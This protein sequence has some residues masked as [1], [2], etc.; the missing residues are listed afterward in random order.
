MAFLLPRPDCPE[1]EKAKDAYKISYL[2]FAELLLKNSS[3]TRARWRRLYN[4]R[5]G[6]KDPL[7]IQWLTHTYGQ[8][9]KAPFISYY[10][11][12]TALDVVH[13]N[14]LE[15]PLVA[16]VTTVN[17]SANAERIRQRDFMKGAML[18]RDEI[19]VVKNVAGVDIMNG[20]EI[21]KDESEFEKLNF[22]DKCEVVMQLMADRQIKRCDV[23]QKIGDSFLDAEVTG[24]GFFKI[25]LDENGK[26][27]PRPIEP[28]RAIFQYSDGDYY[29][30]KSPL[31]GAMEVQSVTKILLSYE[32][33]KDQRDALDAARANPSVYT[34][35]NGLSRGY[36]REESGELMCDV[37]H[38]EWD[39]TE[40]IYTK[41]VPKTKSQLAFDP[42]GDTL[43]F[44]MDAE[45]YEANREFHDKMVAKG[46]YKI[47][48]K[49]RKQKYEATRIGG[50]LNVNMRKVPKKV[51]VDNPSEILSTTYVGFVFGMK[52]GVSVSLQQRVEN[53]SNQYDIIQYQKNREIAKNHGKVLFM[54]DASLGT[55]E[56]QTDRMY[57]MHNDGVV[58]YNSAAA[59]NLGNRNLDPSNMFQERDMGLSPSFAFY[60]QE[61]QNI[62][63]QLRQLTGINDARM[64]QSGV[65]STATG[66]L[67]GK[68][69]SMTITEA[70][71]FAFSGFTKRVVKAII[72]KTAISAAFYQKEEWQQILGA[73]MYSFL[74]EDFIEL[75][76]R[77]YGVEIEDG[78]KYMEIKQIIREMVSV[79]L[80]A[81][82]I[83][84]MD[85][86]NVLTAETVAQM[87]QDL[88][89]AW[90]RMRDFE[91]Q[92]QQAAQQSQEQMAQ[93]QFQTQYQIASETRED[94]Q[95]AK[96]SEIEKKGEVQ[97][98][99]DNNKARNDAFLQ[100]NQ[101]TTDI[102]LQADQNQKR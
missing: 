99:V 30:E 43:E 1:S 95:A 63:N 72:D 57:H 71:F 32:L 60:A 17:A 82:E 58:R 56:K 25:G 91:A 81:K 52:N 84:T 61:E 33:T 86:L 64:G 41:I 59:G 69:A 88:K 73:E 14:F 26:L 21:P 65:S 45:K 35:A 9:N 89:S 54:D 93:Q 40:A 13:G 74:E 102:I 6:I 78:S 19:E 79:S 83:H 16:T 36:M 15:R 23:K 94:N 42:D 47:V 22:K 75:A 50:I 67:E 20:I 90:Q 44:P 76:Y 77:D 100:Q 2:D 11:G 3:N 80:N 97:I 38:I 51:S 37:I 27:D 101:A 48:T 8:E 87:R 49:Y 62:L 55:L 4:V 24:V 12:R 10:M 98:V 18:S 5:N 39:A 28:P 66:V 53:L 29:L 92:Q 70:L 46:E 96:I 34:G 85:A 68:A 31:M 7:S